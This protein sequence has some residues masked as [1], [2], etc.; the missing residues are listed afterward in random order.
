M[1]F[2]QT[3]K[4]KIFFEVNVPR[5]AKALE[6]IADALEENTYVEI[7][8]EV[9]DLDALVKGDDVDDTSTGG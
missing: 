4:G 6:R 9:K 5:I 8:D 2:Y 7:R 1:E 3:K